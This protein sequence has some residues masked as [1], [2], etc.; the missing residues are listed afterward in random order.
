MVSHN[1][2]P[3]DGGPGFFVFGPEREPVVPRIPEK[4]GGNMSKIQVQIQL[5]DRALK[6]F[7]AI[8]DH[9]NI[10]VSQ[11]GA[12]YLKGLVELTPG[13]WLEISRRWDRGVFKLSD[14]IPF[15]IHG[16][17]DFN[18]RALEISVILTRFKLK[19]PH[20]RIWFEKIRG[21]E[22][23]NARVELG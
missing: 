17:V 22:F 21:G 5:T 7:K 20:A 12:K 4:R 16:K 10:L 6:D 3:L 23:L 8:Q 1:P 2:G 19:R 15:D 14:F 18:P 13:S 9:P 11:W